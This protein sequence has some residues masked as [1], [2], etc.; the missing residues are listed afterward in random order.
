MNNESRSN[1]VPLFPE[2]SDDDSSS[3]G[4]DPYIFSI[5]AQSDRP[6]GDDRR[7]APRINT[8]TSRRALLLAKGKRKGSK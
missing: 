7:R 3:S 1:V 6:Y 4:W 8:P 5:V 2:N